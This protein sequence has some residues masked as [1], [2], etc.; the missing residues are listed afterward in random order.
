MSLPNEMYLNFTGFI[1]KQQDANKG[2]RQ[3]ISNYQKIVQNGNSNTVS[4]ES[5]IEKEI[6]NLKEVHSK[7][8][9]AYSNRNAPSQIPGMELDRRQKEI[10]KLGLDI[11]NIENTYKSINNQKYAFKGSMDGEYQQSEEMKTMS[12]S[13]LLQLQKNKIKEQDEQLDEITLEVKKGRVLAKEAGHIIDEQNKQLDTFQE[14]IDRLDSRFKR[15]IKRF[16]NYVAKQSTCC[17]IM[18]LIIEAAIA[19]LIFFILS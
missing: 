9:D 14:E 3:K 7:L 18:T 4:L 10:Q 1:G 13:E 11:Q 12:N 19:F 16:E 2:L 17:I 5:E 15:G 8:N 6:K